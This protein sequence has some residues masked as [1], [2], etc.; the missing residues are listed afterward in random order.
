MPPPRRRGIRF[1]DAASPIVCRL[2]QRVRAYQRER[3]PLGRADRALQHP[4]REPV[5][6]LVPAPVLDEAGTQ[7]RG[8]L[9]GTLMEINNVN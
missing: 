6:P 2:R 8:S 4:R 9:P 1:P 7:T 3:R 5:F